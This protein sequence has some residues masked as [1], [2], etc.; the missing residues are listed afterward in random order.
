MKEIGRETG[1]P[2][3]SLMQEAG[4]EGTVAWTL[5]VAIEMEGSRPTPVSTIAVSHMHI[6]NI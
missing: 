4:L 5:V 6:W 3:G 2:V 1:R